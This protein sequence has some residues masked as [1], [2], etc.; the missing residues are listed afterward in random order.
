[1]LCAQQSAP[2]AI[3]ND[4][5]YSFTY[6]VTLHAEKDE[7]SN[8][9]RIFVRFQVKGLVVRGALS[10][11]ARNFFKGNEPGEREALPTHGNANPSSCPFI[12]AFQLCALTDRYQG[13]PAPAPLYAIH[14]CR[15]R[16]SHVNPRD[17]PGEQ[18]RFPNQHRTPLVRPSAH[19]FQHRVLIDQTSM[20]RHAPRARRVDLV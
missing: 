10:R 18:A 1:M 13:N 15:S 4:Y 19:A 2:L 6:T 9:K 7:Y 16:A 17:G 5:H 14:A 11:G 12:L 3:L 8:K 20:V